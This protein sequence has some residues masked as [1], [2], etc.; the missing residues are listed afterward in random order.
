MNP[1]HERRGVI[2]QNRALTARGLA[3][4]DNRA[5]A[6]ALHSSS[7]LAYF[8]RDWELGVWDQLAT[9][10]YREYGSNE[11]AALVA[12]VVA[13]ANQALG[14]MDRVRQCVEFSLEHGCSRQLVIQ[15][16]A[17]GVHNTLGRAR[18]AAGD[19]GAAVRQ[20]H[21]S[22]E[23]GS[24]PGR[25][26]LIAAGRC[27]QQREQLHLDTEGRGLDHSPRGELSESSAVREAHRQG[28]QSFYR[29]APRRLVQ[30]GAAPFILLDS[31]SLPRSGLHYL[32]ARLEAELGE[33]FS[34]CE[35]YQEPGCCG[36]Q[37]CALTGF[38]EYRR[39]KHRSAVRLVKSH[40]F[41]LTDP[42]I[43]PGYS[44]R[45][46]VL[47]R[48]PL[49]ILTSWF[50]L[51]QLASHKDILSSRGLNVEKIFLKHEP[52][53][54]SAAYQV[55]DEV[56]EPPSLEDLQ[57]WLNRKASYI[58]NFHDKWIGCSWRNQD[59]FVHVIDYGEIDSFVS[60]LLEEI[61]EEK[62]PMGTDRNSR[63]SLTE[64][65]F[66]PRQDPFETRVKPVSE[67]LRYFKEDFVGVAGQIRVKAPGLC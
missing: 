49:Y 42:V 39:D 50:T 8:K 64:E 37:P 59:P 6:E 62:P 16:L 26:S 67:Y 66:K 9:I 48:D 60:R 3:G 45:R 2:G 21:A 51:D 63:A 53:V 40:D 25:V 7:V 52:E 54:L 34:F 36:R 12:L 41:E 55:L 31:K 13:T 29:E 28:L 30:D 47:K 15:V 23:I 11:D 35:W 14:E 17:S 56:F 58:I 24:H 61:G 33:R 22:A 57:N 32:R 27:Q 44:I 18:L 4:Q 1:E 43:Q 19:Q 10:D 46:L 38:M 65:S 20:F 5:L